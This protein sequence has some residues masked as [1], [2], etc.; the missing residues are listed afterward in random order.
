MNFINQLFN[1]S[2]T[3]FDPLNFVGVIITI[4]ASIYIFKS[5]VS[6]SFSRERHDK[7]I[8]PLFDLL[9]PILYQQPQSDVLE[10]ALQ[11][12]NNNRNFADGKL[13]EICYFC[14]K[15]PS[16]ENFKS[17]CSYVDK[18][19]DKSCR[20]LG[21]KTRGL[22]YR[23]YRSQYKSKFHFILSI[24]IYALASFAVGISFFFLFLFCLLNA[25][26]MLF[27]SVNPVQ[28]LSILISCAIL[29]FTFV[30]YIEKNPK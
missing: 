29:I 22:T 19:Y 1:S 15:N 12:I 18:A 17:L 24:T 7:L 4:F 26:D 3:S 20:K 21:L 10:K 23:I 14:T 5:E 8:F 27:K 25:V 2:Q 9:E 6:I 28:Q 16:V 30:K 11:I 13:L